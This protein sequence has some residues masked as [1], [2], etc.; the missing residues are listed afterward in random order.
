MRP[1]AGRRR[2]LAWGFTL[3]KSSLPPC[4]RTGLFGRESR[5]LGARKAGCLGVWITSSTRGY[6]SGSKRWLSK[7]SSL[8]GKGEESIDRSFDRAG[9]PK[10]LTE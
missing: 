9:T 7:G 8:D 3:A 1:H 5:W 6:P 2:H 10:Y 4:R